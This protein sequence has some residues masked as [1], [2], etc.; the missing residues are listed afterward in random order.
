MSPLIK[1]QADRQSGLVVF[2]ITGFISTIASLCEI[3][4]R[5]HLE[6]WITTSAKSLNVGHLCLSHR[7]VI[8]AVLKQ[9]IQHS[10]PVCRSDLLLVD[11]LADNL[12]C[13]AGQS[14]L[15]TVKNGHTCWKIFRNNHKEEGESVSMQCAC[16]LK[17]GSD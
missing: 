6:L 1:T 3:L 16:G 9:R 11:H 5:S 4:E 15:F 8:P 2:I 14:P 12:L 10:F 17:G 13:D 7:W